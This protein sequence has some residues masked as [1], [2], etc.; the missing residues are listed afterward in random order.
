MFSCT[1]SF[2]ISLFFSHRLISYYPY[3]NIWPHL[4]L[5][6]SVTKICNHIAFYLYVQYT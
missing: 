1:L 3:Y 5:A 6:A 2:V 4:A